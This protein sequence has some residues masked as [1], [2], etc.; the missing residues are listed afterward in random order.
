MSDDP[1]KLSIGVAILLAALLATT[2]T[3]TCSNSRLEERVIDLERD[4]REGGGAGGA[5]AGATTGAPAVAPVIV[6]VPPAQASSNDATSRLEDRIFRI[7]SALMSGGARPATGPIADLAPRAE[8]SSKPEEKRPDVS[9]VAAGA[10][11]GIFAVGAGGVRAEILRVEGATPEGA[12]RLSDK[13]YPQQD[14]YVNRRSQ[15]PRTLNYYATNEG[16]ASTITSYILGRL[17][18]V[19]P[20][21]PPELLD[22]LA[23]SWD[24]SDDKLTYTYHLRKGVQFADGRPFTSADVKFSFDV[25]RD[26]DVRSD[27]IRS[28]FEDVVSLDTPDPYTVV[29][30]YRERYWKGLFTVGYTL[31]MLDR[32]WYE[33]QIPIW[34]K[35][36]D[37]TKF[38]TTPGQPGFGDVFN[39]ISIPCPGTGPYYLESSDDFTRSK[40]VLV[41][42]PFYYGQQIHPDRYNFRKLRWVFI[43]DEVAAFEAFRKQQFDVSVTDFDKW[44]DELSKDPTITDISKFF[45]YDHT[46]LD[47]SY[48]AWNCRRPPF[49]D[50]RVRTAMT[51]LVDREWII[52]EIERGRGTIAVC[53]SKRIY[54][55]YSND[56]EPHKFDLDAARKLLAEAG[57]K[58]TNGDG[59][60]DRNGKPFEFKLKM[61]STR[62]FYT[63]ISGQL[64][65]ACKQVGINMVPEPAEW[66]TFI[67]DLNNHRFDAVML[68]S[69]W[70]D[71]WIDHYENYHSSQDRKDGNNISGW[72]DPEVDKILEEHK[73]EFDPQ[74]RIE[75]FH[76]FN[77]M[78]YDAQPETLLVHSLVPVL[79]NKRFENLKVRPSGLQMFDW[80]VRDANVLYK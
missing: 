15:A 65:Q 36:L 9:R 19:D 3:M 11:T 30:R 57:W 7:E 39:K 21:H 47:C 27:H 78:F 10:G 42:N 28:Q 16:D 49:D 24:V 5:A 35:R 41:Q 26:P 43:D 17:I 44:E 51:H 8:T 14:E 34:A 59:F 13:T 29:A 33:E 25:M 32:G 2:L 56:L 73:Q 60:L 50:A 67:E 63:R 61:G 38:S 18:G 55:T 4:L 31:R 80:W 40:V 12:V 75:L 74:K 22:A 1:S 77:K 72:R 46:G 64:K 70:N 79:V 48:I 53:K 66:A 68:F 52:K 71:P 58:D 69:S 23:T 54:P 37:I 20:D 62:A 45:E 6:N 76:K